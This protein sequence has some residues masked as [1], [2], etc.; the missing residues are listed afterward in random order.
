MTL[1]EK[2][3]SLN[4]P[5][6]QYV[7]IGSGVLEALGL[8]KANDVDI[9]VT[10][11]LYGR[12]RKTNEWE[13]E[14]R[15]SKIFLKKGKIEINPKLDW[16]EFPVTAQEAISSALIVGN[17]PFMNL[18]HTRQFKQALGREKDIKD[19]QLIEE[20]LAKINPK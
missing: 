20:Y 12:L 8:R 9:S 5:L 13:E 18:K 6:G 17:I 14:E 19:I 3:R 7:V 10:T 1:I 4:F 15:H 11:E 2:V 16:D